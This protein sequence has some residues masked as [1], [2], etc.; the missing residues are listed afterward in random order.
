MPAA[1]RSTLH[2]GWHGAIAL[3]TSHNRPGDPCHLVG[4]SDSDQ[5]GW[6][7]L[8]QLI[9]PDA[10][11]SLLLPRT[12]NDG[13]G[14]NDKEM[15]QIAVSHFRYAH[16]QLAAGRVLLW[17][18]AEP[19]G[20]LPAGT[21]HFR[22]A[23]SAVAVMKPM[24]GIVSSRWQVG[25]ARCQAISPLTLGFAFRNPCCRPKKLSVPQ[26]ISRETG[27]ISIVSPANESGAQRN[28]PLI[29]VEMPANGGL[30]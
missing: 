17:H 16:S 5:T 19:S 15:P 9:C 3:F 13:S 20:K 10:D 22:V 28:H 27:A 2:S 23:A 18:Q 29:V 30:F 7:S 26:N 11:G 25:S 6:L 4:D 24:P 12:P 14:S 1:Y 21:E 8:Q